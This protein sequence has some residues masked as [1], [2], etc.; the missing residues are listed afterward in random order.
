MPRRIGKVPPSGPLTARIVAIS[1]APDEHEERLGR[2]FAG[3]SG[4]WWEQWLTAASLHREDIY[5]DNVFPYRCPGNKIKH[6]PRDEIE[7]WANN[8]HARLTALKDPI[9]IVP[10]GNV[11]LRAL[12][13][14]PLWAHTSR[15]IGDWRGS[16]LP[17]HMTDGRQAKI[18][19]TYHSAAT[20]RDNSLVKLIVAD[21]C[22]VAADQ[23]F[24]KLRHPVYTSYI[25]GHTR[26]GTLERYL[27]AARDP[28]VVMAIDIECP[29]K[30]MACV[31]FSFH[32]DESLTL[33]WPDDYAAIKTLCESPCR[34]VGQNFR[35]DRYWLH[36]PSGLAELSRK[37]WLM[38]RLPTIRV[39]G[40]IFDLLDMH[41]AL[42]STLP[43]DLA[44]MASLDTRQPYWKKS[45][46]DSDEVDRTP[47]DDLCLY[48]GI[49]CCVTRYLYDIYT[50]RLKE[51][52]YD[53]PQDFQ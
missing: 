6:G 3:P 31:G 1:E 11:A 10:M 53:E 24:Y 40:R 2:P 25:P 51:T 18:I 44:T 15:K 12:T 8:L 41:H 47:F 46:K 42:D 49:D 50:T 36:P 27:D 20:F 13:R 9:V 52:H 48:N 14:E 22:R 29:N 45:W 30:R 19:P 38:P 32:P 5:V 26:R 35:F 37:H 39:A 43:H 33:R 7:T 16:I 28:A 17:Y 34:K 23:H 21:W 4:Y